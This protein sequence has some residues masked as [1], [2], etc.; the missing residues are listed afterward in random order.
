MN[1]LDWGKDIGAHGRQACE[2]GLCRRSCLFFER[3]FDPLQSLFL[4]LQLSD[5]GADGA[6]ASLFL[7]Q[8]GCMR[9]ARGELLLRHHKLTNWRT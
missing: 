7:R 1:A 6:V 3:I 5:K 2:L 4:L 9:M 8:G